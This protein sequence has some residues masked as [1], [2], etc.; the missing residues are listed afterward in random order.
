MVKNAISLVLLISLLAILLSVIGCGEPARGKIVFTSGRDYKI[1]D[2][3]IDTF[4]TSI[5]SEIYIM[6]E[7]GL[8]QTR[9]TNIASVK[10]QPVFSPDSTKIAFAS[11]ERDGNWDIYVIN[12]DGSDMKHLT[13]NPG[14]D[15]QQSWSPDNSQIAYISQREDNGELWLMNA[16]GTNQTRLTDTPAHYYPPAWS[17]DG[18]KIIYC[19]AKDN[20]PFDIYVINSDGTHNTRLTDSTTHNFTP[21]WS[22]DGKKIAYSSSKD[23]GSLNIYVMNADGSNQTR[24]TDNV[25][26]D[27][28]P[29]WSP[30][31]R[32]IAFY[33]RKEYSPEND[34]MVKYTI[35]VMNADGSNLRR[36]TNDTGDNPGPSMGDIY[37]KWSPD[38]SRIVFQSQRDCNWEIYM[39]NADGS[40]LVRLTQDTENDEWPDWSIK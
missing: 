23:S 17:P 31:G 12:T 8:N 16:D 5:S 9:L 13:D 37:P 4:K 25:G 35:C 3:T 32:K 27:I 34:E 38:G 2:L 33:S 6:G 7:D 40:N 11:A 24:L 20:L 36:L 14:Y 26:I 29:D 21:A 30:D 1:E 39:I 15:F 28:L 10:Y 18:E 19:S 22:P